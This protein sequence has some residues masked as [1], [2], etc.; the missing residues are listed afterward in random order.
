MH[1]RVQQEDGGGG[2]A[3]VQRTRRTRVRTIAGAA[4]DTPFFIRSRQSR[5]ASWFMR[6][7]PHPTV[8]D[9]MIQ[10]CRDTRNT[11]E[12]HGPEYFGMSGRDAPRNSE[13]LPPF[14]FDGF[15]EQKM[16]AELVQCLPDE[17]Y[18]LASEGPVTIEAVR[19]AFPIRTRPS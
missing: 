5:R 4:Y 8:R 1:G 2:R 9:A 3:L 18:G 15:R 14:R 11:F 10:R 16:R 17:L 19:R 12:R 6:L 7:S 13:T